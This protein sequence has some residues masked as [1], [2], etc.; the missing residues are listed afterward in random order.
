MLYTFKGL[1]GAQPAERLI[2]VNGAFYGTTTY[3][4]TG[5]CA[6]S[7][8]VVGCGSVFK[9]SMSGVE[10]VLYSFK[11]KPDGLYPAAGLTRAQGKLYGTTLY[12]GTFNKGTV[13]EI[14]TSGKERVL[15]SF[16]GAPDGSYPT[17]LLNVRGTLYG[18]T[19][20]GGD[21]RC[22]GGCGTVF[23]FTP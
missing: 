16:K 6:V 8:V 3:G 23:A 4:G 18:T 22:R 17:G 7:K 10:Q 9:L 15:Y 13:Y 21:R 2:E 14:S 11:G 1:D 19:G 5:K 12:G 20:A